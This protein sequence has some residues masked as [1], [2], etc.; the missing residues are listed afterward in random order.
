MNT[1]AHVDSLNI[2]ALGSQQHFTNVI[3]GIYGTFSI[4]SG[5]VCYIQTKAKIGNDG[6][7]H[8]QLTRALVPAREALNIQEM[9]FNQLLQR[10]LDDHRIAIKLIPYILDSPVN[11]LPGFFPPV[12]AVLLPFDSHQQPE[13]YF[14][15]PEESVEVDHQY[16]AR[17][18]MITLGKACRIQRL[19]GN[20]DKPATVPLAVLRWNPDAA[21]LVIMDGQHRAM[22][23]LAIE[24]SVTKS[25]HMAPK[26]AR[27]QPFYEEHVKKWLDK[28]SNEGRP[29]DLSQIELPVTICWFPE[30]PGQSPR[31]RPHKAARKLFVDVNNTA[32]PPSEARLVLL[33]DTKLENIFARELL[34]QLRKDSFWQDQFPLY[35][36]EYDNPNAAVTTPRRWSVVTNLE[37]LKDSVLRVIFGPPKIIE[38]V[39]ASLQG[40]PS[41]RDMNKHMRDQLQ[42][43]KLFAKEIH[44]GPRILL[45]ESLGN[46]IFPIN[47]QLLHSKLLD[48]FYKRFGKGILY[49]LSNVE[50]FKAHLQSLRDRYYGW[51]AAD[52]VQ[53]LAKDA[54]FEGVGMFWTIDDG[55]NLWLDQC[56]EARDEKQKEPP[57]PDVSR[58]WNILE[59]EQKLEFRKRRSE[60]YLQSTSP[61]DIEDSD[62][63]FQG[64]VTYAAQVG[65]I[66]AWASIHHISAVACDPFILAQ[67]IT[68][69]INNA[70]T[71]GPTKHKNRR[72]IF[73]KK[74][75]EHGFKPLNELPKLEP[76]YASQFRYFWLEL[77]LIPENQPS[78]T[79]NGVDIAKALNL[80][81]KSRQVYL[82]LL[83]EDRRKQRLKDAAVRA[84]PDS[85]QQAKRAAELAREEIIEG[86]ALARQYWFGGKI[87]DCRKFIESTLDQSQLIEI[88][89]EN[90]DP[91]D[92]GEY[93]DNSENQI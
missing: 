71:S 37:I 14:P 24:R 4:P 65:L 19:L 48:A 80:L 79:A 78:L 58:A 39:T 35:G 33:S 85:S 70:I 62:L 45:R 86:Q 83:I 7:S 93:N 52:N 25:W 44:D 18:Q 26:G 91:E 43:D 66:L 88:T 57:Q 12:V 1:N 60:V 15:P 74:S 32:K 82:K 67:E 69:A 30:K 77:I 6:S 50:P 61:Q 51:T 75:K 68:K 34:N 55:H 41:S 40:K 53:T 72:R 8:S 90:S 76:A 28:A 11:G 64:L 92:E 9:D 3:D 22:S 56:K 73:L 49:L 31:P 84:L 59:K 47:D 21:K 89:D 16:S 29:I 27:Y 20:D 87:A 13:E 2:G 81:E 38:N 5:N 46:H 10:D 63:L 17:F 23:L 36:I 54:L 42:V